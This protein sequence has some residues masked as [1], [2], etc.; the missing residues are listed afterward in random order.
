M[1]IGQG[2]WKEWDVRVWFRITRE[3]SEVT[4]ESYVIERKGRWGAPVVL[5]TGDE[6]E[7]LIDFRMKGVVPSGKTEDGRW[8][9]RGR[10][11]EWRCKSWSF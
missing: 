11:I 8:T 4:D 1:E 5:L 2:E 9:G 3:G 6:K 7:V 10:T